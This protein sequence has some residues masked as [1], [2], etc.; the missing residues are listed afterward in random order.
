MNDISAL[1]HWLLHIWSFSWKRNISSE[2]NFEGDDGIWYVS[3]PALFRHQ[4]YGALLVWCGRPSEV[5]LVFG[6]WW[7]VFSI[8]IFH[9]ALILLN[10]KSRTRL[11][12]GGPL[13]LLT[14]NN[15]C[16]KHISQT[17]IITQA[18]T[19]TSVFFGHGGAG[20]Q[21]SRFSGV[22]IIFIYV[23]VFFLLCDAENNFSDNFLFGDCNWL[24]PF[25]SWL[26]IVNIL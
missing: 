24:N 8:L 16:Y 23:Q 12:A 4:L 26:S 5:F 10:L 25:N 3:T 6:I 21:D 9:Q 2:N 13:G 7:Y 15:P 14:S 19:M 11:Q 18:N 20:D 22:R 17:N 1:I